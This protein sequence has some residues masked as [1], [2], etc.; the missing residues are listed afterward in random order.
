MVRGF[1]P[2]SWRGWASPMSPV[3]L[4]LRGPDLAMSAWD[5]ASSSPRPFLS[6]PR[7]RWTFTTDGAAARSSPPA[8]EEARLRRP[9]YR[10]DLNSAYSIGRRPPARAENVNRACRHAQTGDIVSCAVHSPVT[11]G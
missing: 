4:E 8:G 9:R 2:T 1:P 11:L 5:L 10:G 3:V 6:G 7:R